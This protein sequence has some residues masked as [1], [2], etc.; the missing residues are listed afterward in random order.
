VRRRKNA[1][2]M[3][4]LSP[5]LFERGSNGV[6]TSAFVDDL[7]GRMT[8]YEH[9]IVAKGGFESCRIGYLGTLE[10]ARW[11]FMGRTPKYAGRGFVAV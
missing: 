7:R 10:E 5:I 8:S 1:S 4:I 2:S 3:I 11:W 9:T 6:P